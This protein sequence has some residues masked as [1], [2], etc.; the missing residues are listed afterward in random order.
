M[1]R[2]LS[3]EDYDLAFASSGAEALAKAAELTPDLILL[4]VMMPV[5]DGFE[6]CRR[7]R[8]DP[9]LAQVPVIMVT[10][11]DDRDSR[12][13]GIEAGA[14]DFIAKPFDEMELQVRVRAITKL[15]RYR[16]L[17]SERAKF[18]R[19]IE[20]SPNGIMIVDARGT[21]CLANPAML[22]LVGAEREKD[23]VGKKVQVFVAPEQL[24]YFSSFL[25]GVA[26][27][28]SPAA[29]VET[30]FVRLDSESFPVQVDAGRFEWDGGPAVQ[31]VVRDIAERKRAEQALRQ[32]NRE[33]ALLNRASQAFSS[34]LDM[35]RVLVAV[36]QE[37]RHLLDVVACSVW[38]IEPGTGEL[39]C[40]HANGPQSE[41]VRGWRLPPGEGLVGWVARSGKSLIVPDAWADQRH[42]EG[43][44]QR[45]GLALRSILSAPL[46]VKENV[47]GVLQVVDAEVA[48]FTLTDLTLVESL[49]ASAATA[50]EN[51]R[52]FEQGQREIEERKRAE[53]TLRRRNEDLV[54]LNAVA[55]T[56]GQ[57]FDLKQIL[58]AA[59]DKVL[60]VIEADAGWV[61]L[62]DEKG[63]VLSL[64]K[65]GVLSLSKGGVLS[66]SKGGDSPSLVAYCGQLREM[67]ETP[68]TCKWAKSIMAEVVQSGQAVVI[69]QSSDALQSR[70]E[71]GREDPCHVIVGVPIKARE[72]VLGL[73]GLCSFA[74]RQPSSQEVQLLTAIGHQIGVALENARLT[75]EA[76]EVEILREL[77][78]LR[79][80]L[81]ANVSH[82]FRT[83]LGLIK[84]FCTT[85]LREDVE[86]DRE[87][88]REFLGHLDEEAE[89]LERIVDNLLDLAQMED[90]RLRLDKRPTDVGQ[91]VRKVMGAMEIQL[92]QHRFVYDFPAESLVAAVD[93]KRVEEVL[94]NLLS[95]AIKYSPEGG[96]I[97]VQ[98]RGDRRQLLIWVRDQGMGIP[99]QS[100]ERVFERFYRVENE[101][102]QSVRGAG[103]GLAVCRGII[104]AHGGR[105]WAES[106]LGVGSTFYFSLP[107]GDSPSTAL[108][109][110]PP[111]LG[112]RTKG[113]GQGSGHRSESHTNQ[114][115][116]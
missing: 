70:V 28:V 60:E 115:R 29:H 45:T 101:I 26:T 51:A 80:E 81:I 17:L 24:G 1:E 32:R 18:E 116:Q 2:L 4:D 30:S 46:R 37:V 6:A 5:M 21:I 65:G 100:L 16:R 66:L 53:E 67:A 102:T 7:L 22:R 77:D 63:G 71:A 14:D 44:D 98:G 52:L 62:L 103:L 91:L 48:R 110:G 27:D 49:A 50:I 57:S 96:T 105:M 106:T 31:I 59:L 54:A 35:D 104:G 33:L 97:T 72:K 3:A 111:S 79:S 108:R 64:S 86:F 82:E 8:A 76:A 12:L 36:L 23:V 99:S 93:A 90:G 68:R 84:I 41:I 34:T 95:N 38:L 47:I 9:L 75:K 78:R 83:P 89:K 20:L 56:I 114:S 39:V 25:D 85:L 88:Q 55:T 10:A 11:L 87:T 112:R 58:N 19:A 40:R 42:F 61:Q 73:V 109:R 92:T 74:P 13:R 43:V 69:T 94:R 15:D 107:V 113:S